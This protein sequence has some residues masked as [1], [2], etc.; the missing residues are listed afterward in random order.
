[1]WWQYF[2]V[3]IG[4]FVLDVVPVP[5]PP[6]CTAMIFLQIKFDLDVWPVIIIGVLGSILGR[7]LLAMYIPYL[8]GKIFNK[9]KNQ[10]VQFLGKKLKEKGWK[11]PLFILVYSLI[12]LPTTPLFLAGGMARMKPLYMVLPFMVGK[13]IGDMTAVLTANYAAEN[14]ED[15]KEGMISWKSILSLA[16]GLILVFALLFIDWETLIRQKKLKLKFSIWVK[17]VKEVSEKRKNKK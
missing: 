4:A 14:I 5:L 3:F 6:A 9:A 13:F 12:P 2:L 1:M 11:G 15:L 8:S 7:F 10:D 17:K 16:L